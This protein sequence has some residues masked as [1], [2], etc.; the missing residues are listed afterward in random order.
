MNVRT[1]CSTQDL[2]AAVA[3]LKAQCG[4]FVPRLVLFFASSRYVPSELARLMRI[5]FPGTRL[6]GC[7]TAGEI[8]HGKMRDHS[9]V[10]M[11]LDSELVEDAALAV[12]PGLSAGAGVA[13]ALRE[14]E[15]HFHAPLASLDLARHAGIVLMD[16]LSGA[17]ER[18][19]EELGDATDIPFVGGSAGD[20][21]QFQQTHVMADGHAYTDAAVLVLLRLKRPFDIVKTQ[22]FRS[23]GKVLVATK[24]EESCRKVWEFD[25]QPA[26]HAYA[27]ALGVSPETAPELFFRHPLGLMAG[28]EP[29]VRSPRLVEDGAMLFYCR[30]SEGMELEVLNATDIVSDTRAALEAQKS[31]GAIHGLIEFQCILRAVQLRQEWRCNQYDQIFAGV[32]TIGFATYGEAYLGH[33]NQTSTML[34]FR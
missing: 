23:S 5:S 21:L 26:L 13:E 24:V 29:F 30:I 28:N 33:I 12:I 10:A 19:M 20:D 1:A 22:S 15:S 2:P 7:S 6:A 17:E 11:F 27:R 25:R 34:V 4:E 9:V 8:G 32:P 3:E 14:F 16:G 31:A 18:L